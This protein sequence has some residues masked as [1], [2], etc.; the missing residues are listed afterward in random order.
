VYCLHNRMI[1][2]HVDDSLNTEQLTVK[3]LMTNVESYSVKSMSWFSDWLRGMRHRNSSEC[4]LPQVRVFVCEGFRHITPL[5]RMNTSSCSKSGVVQLF[6]SPFAGYR[7]PTFQDH[8]L[9][10]A[11]EFTPVADILFRLTI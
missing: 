1:T 3:V 11:R 7:N 4:S 6:P 10:I 5:L 2:L 8:K 9:T